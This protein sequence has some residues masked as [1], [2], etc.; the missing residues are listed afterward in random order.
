MV[1]LNAS[2]QS[3]GVGVEA[4]RGD[5]VLLNV[6]G[7]VSV[8][9]TVHDVHVRDRQD[10]AVGA[11]D[12]AVQR[13]AGGLGGSV[14]SSQGDAQ[15]GV[16]AQLAL[17]RGAVELDHQVVQSALV[18]SVHADDLRSDDL[19][20]GLDRVKNTLAAVDGLVAIATLP[21]LGL[22][23]GGAGRDQAQALGA[24]F[25][26]QNDLNG[27][28]AAGIENLTRVHAFNYCHNYSLKRLCIL[29]D[30]LKSSAIC[31]R[32]EQHAQNLAL[33]LTMPVCRLIA[34]QYGRNRSVN[35]LAIEV[36]DLTVGQ[37]QFAG[38]E[39]VLNLLRVSGRGNREQILVLRKFP[40]E[41]DA[42]VG[43]VVN[44]GD[45]AEPVE[46]MLVERVKES[47]ERR[48][49]DK[50]QT[51][52]FA[53]FQRVLRVAVDR[54]E[55][56]LDGHE[57]ISQNIVGGFDVRVVDSGDADSFGHTFVHELL[58]CAH[59]VF[60]RHLRIVAV[61]VEQIERIDTE[62]AG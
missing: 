57:T 19:V 15:D 13:Q 7:E 40:R 14:Q 62:A 46:Q 18:S 28:V 22:T 51:E 36:A 59:L 42:L 48:P 23:G 29:N 33:A 11:A 9:A 60:V 49:A 10:V 21:S 4:V 58:E 53:G 2:A 50:S 1:D 30:I 6:G 61:R 41:R 47:T 17:V 27:R 45:F 25:G 31:G 26:V 38:F 35:V 34:R 54:G 44:L 52:L 55:L 43:A 37:F 8:S 5:H 12:V 20:H 24:V 39:R 56:V 16:G 32:C 3:L